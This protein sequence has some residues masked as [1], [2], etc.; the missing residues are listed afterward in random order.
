MNDVGDGS[1][2]STRSAGE[3]GSSDYS[4]CESMSSPCILKNKGA[5]KQRCQKTKKKTKVSSTVFAIQVISV[6]VLAVELSTPAPV[7]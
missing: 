4:L 2:E 7:V 3:W 6:V 1:V 5:K